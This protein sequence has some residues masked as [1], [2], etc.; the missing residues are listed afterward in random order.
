VN[1]ALEPLRKVLATHLPPWFAPYDAPMRQVLHLA[2]DRPVAEALNQAMGSCAPPLAASPLRFVPQSEL[3]DG[4][5]YEAFIHRT[6]QV[7]TR[8]NLHDFFN[9]IV[10]LRFPQ[11]KRRLNEL[12]AQA[13]A[14][15]GIGPVRGAVRDALTLFDENAAWLQADADPVDALR[16]RDWHGAFVARRPDWAHTPVVCFGHA[17][18]EKL[19]QP[20][21]PITAHVWAV[22]V[23]ADASDWLAA[24]LTPE[25]LATKPHLPLPVLGIPG[26]WAPNESA[27]FY[28]DPSVFRPARARAEPGTHHTA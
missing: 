26:W 25:V 2:A 3:P 24:H 4:E 8:D 27:D 13:I 10:W 14:R 9:G 20:R 1:A 12:Q 15:G 19:V 6:A 28:A 7:P 21:T 17:L 22:P 16:R 11:L 23:D 5:A 18:L